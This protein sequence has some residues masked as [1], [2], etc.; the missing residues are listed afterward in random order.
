MDVLESVVAV[1]SLLREFT[2]LL[3]CEKEDSVPAIQPLLHHIQ[4]T[5]LANKPDGNL[6]KE[7]R[8]RIQISLYSEKI[9]LF[10]CIGTFL[11]PRLKLNTSIIEATKESVKDKME[12]VG[13]PTTSPALSTEEEDCYQLPNKTNKTAWGKYLVIKSQA[14]ASLESWSR[15]EKGI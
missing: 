14:N 6:T 11:D 10:L 12:Q 15:V 13:Q 5:I 9:T 3:A 1:L 2:N 4:D 8:A 7:I